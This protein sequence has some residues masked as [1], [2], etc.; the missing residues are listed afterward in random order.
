MSTFSK[1]LAESLI[2][3][4]RSI[5]KCNEVVNYV[6]NNGHKGGLLAKGYLQWGYPA[7]F[8]E[9]GVVVVTKDGSHVGIYISDTEFIH[10]SESRQEVVKKHKSEEIYIFG[11]DRIYRKNW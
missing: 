1:P 10:S 2:G 4:S 8:P 11:S 7:A 6:L 5:Y 3:K 9:A